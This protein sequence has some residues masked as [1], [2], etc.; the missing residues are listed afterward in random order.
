M[1]IKEEKAIIIAADLE[2]ASALDL[3]TLQM[4]VNEIASW[5]DHFAQLVN[6]DSAFFNPVIDG[7]LIAIPVNHLQN[8]EVRTNVHSR[9]LDACQRWIASAQG[10]SRSL[11]LRIAVHYSDVLVFENGLGPIIIGRGA[12]HSSR[13]VRLAIGKQVV[14]SEEYVESWRERN[15]NEFMRFAGANMLYPNPNDGQPPFLFWQKANTPSRVRY[16]VD[17]DPSQR[18]SSPA[19]MRAHLAVRNAQSL[20]SEM[21]YDLAVYL[22]QLRDVSHQMPSSI[23]EEQQKE[24]DRQLFGRI[25]I[26]RPNPSNPNELRCWLRLERDYFEHEKL[27][28]ANTADPARTLMDEYPSSTS[29]SVN[30]PKGPVGF[31]FKDNVPIVVPSLPPWNSRA[32]KEIY[33]SIMSKYNMT[34]QEVN[35]LRHHSR[36]YFAIPFSESDLETDESAS[37]SKESVV[38]TGVLC[39]D[40]DEP[41]SVSREGLIDFFLEYAV[42]RFSFVA[43]CLMREGS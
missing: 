33:R 16:V 22:E 14:L 40:W 31:A 1:T 20:M 9:V 41:L 8:D 39:V 25:S 3:A 19:A 18:V 27:N 6:R 30:P 34:D 10:I 11:A 21:Q 29:Y 36:A 13:L 12:S 26:Y 42:Y 15:A 38:P 17:P 4:G 43:A 5:H 37:N 32:Q 24:L 2:N 28:A 7:A 35:G 23:A